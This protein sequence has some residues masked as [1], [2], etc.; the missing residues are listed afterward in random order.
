MTKTTYTIRV[1]F[2]GNRY[3]LETHD[4]DI[5]ETHSQSGHTV[6]ARTEGT[7]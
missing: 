4:P 5:A 1:W 6:T 2:K 3:D 7:A